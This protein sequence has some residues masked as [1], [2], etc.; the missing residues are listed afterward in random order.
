MEAEKPS[1]KTPV[2][3]SQKRKQRPRQEDEVEEEVSTVFCFSRLMRN[4]SGKT[5]AKVFHR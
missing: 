4:Y 1:L 2:E 3:K 5:S